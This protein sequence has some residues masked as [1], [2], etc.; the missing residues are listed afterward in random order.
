MGIVLIHL[1][2]LVIYNVAGL[3]HFSLWIFVLY[4]VCCAFTFGYFAEYIRSC[5]ICRLFPPQYALPFIL[6]LIIS[7]NK[8]S[9]LSLCPIHLYM[10]FFCMVCIDVLVGRWCKFSWNAA[11][12]DQCCQEE[13]LSSVRVS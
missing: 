3:F 11:A 12:E 10:I 5:C 7:C 1:L 9:F 4:I 6:P 2:L 8:S 13:T